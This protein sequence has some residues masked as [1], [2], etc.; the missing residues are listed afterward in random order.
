MV[1]TFQRRFVIGTVTLAVII[2]IIATP[3]ILSGDLRLDVA[4]RL[5]L[6][7]GWEAEQIADGDDGMV[8]VVLPLPAVDGMVAD[9]YRYKAQFLA[10]P[11]DE[12]MRLTDIDSGHQLT[13]PLREIEH[14]AAD[15]EGAHVLFRGPAGSGDETAVLVDVAALN[16]TQ[17]A[18]G[19]MTPDLPGDWEIPVWEKT[20]GP[21]DRFS[22]SGAYLACFNRPELATYLAGDWQIDVQVTGDFRRRVD[23]FRGNGFRPI[24]GW[25][26]DDTDIYLYN[27]QGI[28][29]VPVPLDKLAGD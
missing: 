25:A 12:G 2:A 5:H 23:L 7:P 22:V 24:V 10:L 28:W 20:T 26:N 13:I 11:S 19:T 9:R 16:A 1:K 4:H 18:P 6:A 27:E 21:C 8:L 29:R 3:L 15:A 14:I 17:L